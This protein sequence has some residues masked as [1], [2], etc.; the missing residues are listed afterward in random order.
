MYIIYSML[1]CDLRGLGDVGD[2]EGSLAE[3]VHHA[4]EKRSVIGCQ[5]ERGVDGVQHVRVDIGQCLVG[6]Q[7]CVHPRKLLNNEQ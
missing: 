2:K 6:V 4:R 7:C 3:A 1:M 5:V